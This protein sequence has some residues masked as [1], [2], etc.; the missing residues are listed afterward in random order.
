MPDQSVVATRHRWTASELRRLPEHERNAI[1]EAAAT[2]VEAE[3][4]DNLELTDFRA[5][6]KEDLHGD[7]ASAETR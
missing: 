1:L 7:S 4:R 6:G 5:F 2:A 3:Y